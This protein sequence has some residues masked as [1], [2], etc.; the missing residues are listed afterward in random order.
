MFFFHKKLSKNL[1]LV[2][3]NY[4]SGSKTN[5]REFRKILRDR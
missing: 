1:V 3:R 4:G 5:G 2:Y